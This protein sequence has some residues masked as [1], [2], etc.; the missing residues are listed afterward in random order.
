MCTE[1]ECHERQ[2]SGEISL[3]ECQWP[4]PSGSSNKDTMDGALPTSLPRGGKQSRRL[5][6]R[7]YAMTKYRR[8]AAGSKAREPSRSI[9]Q[10]HCCLDQLEYILAYQQKPST[11][12]DNNNNNK[13]NAFPKQSLT[14][15][16][17]FVEDRIRAIQVDMIVSQQPSAAIQYRIVKCHIL[18]LYLLGSSAT[19]ESK[20][21]QQ[22]LSAALTNY[23]EETSSN[24]STQNQ[25]RDDNILC[26]MALHQLSQYYNSKMNSNESF[27][28]ILDYYRRNVPIQRQHL[29]HFPKFQWALHLVHLSLMGRP[30]SILRQLA[31]LDVVTKTGRRST[32]LAVLFRCCMAPVI[33]ELRFQ[34]LDQYN[35]IYMKGEK[36][37]VQELARLLYFGS[38]Q[39]AYDFCTQMAGLTKFE[40]TDDVLEHNSKI[41]FKIGPVV[42][43]DKLGVHRQQDAFVFGNLYNDFWR[44]NVRSE[45]NK[46]TAWDDMVPGKGLG[47]VDEGITGSRFDD[48]GV[49]VPPP[50]LLHRVLVSS[51]T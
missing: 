51:T 31:E 48:E 49:F 45:H 4:S 50:A 16:V 43:S 33:D 2:T 9:K 46:A 42:R 47:D 5:V 13:N 34:A 18:I 32:E 39:D 20:F 21:G 38:S 22:A 1:A 29:I 37:H 28:F 10:L 41:V 8:S 23:W 35:T 36:V 6:D 11:N 12:D 24:H 17:G 7:H 14:G 19:Y 30:Q 25:E 3:F 27:S 26:F 40:T 15:T 44:S